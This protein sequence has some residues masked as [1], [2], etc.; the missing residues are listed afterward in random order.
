M[1]ARPSWHWFVFAIVLLA[2]LLLFSMAVL[3]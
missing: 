2:V 1:T 3:Q